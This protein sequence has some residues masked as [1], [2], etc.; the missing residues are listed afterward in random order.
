MDAFDK[1]FT[2][3]R[4]GQVCHLHLAHMSMEKLEAKKRRTKAYICST[5]HVETSSWDEEEILSVS[6]PWWRQ[7][8][9]SR[10]SRSV[11][12][13]LGMTYSTIKCFRARRARS[14]IAAHRERSRMLGVAVV[15]VGRKRLLKGEAVLSPWEIGL[16]G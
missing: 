15:V 16:L 12:G 11:N 14:I 10:P 4:D 13:E 5:P 3:T 6:A 1:E 8:L 7:K 9:A 2:V